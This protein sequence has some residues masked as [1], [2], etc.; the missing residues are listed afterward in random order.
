MDGFV[1]TCFPD[2]LRTTPKGGWSSKGKSLPRG[3][4]SR[5]LEGIERMS[6]LDRGAHPGDRANMEHLEQPLEH[7]VWSV[8]GS[9]RH[10]R[11]ILEKED[12]PL[13]QGLARGSP[14]NPGAQDT[15][16]GGMKP[17]TDHPT[18]LAECCAV[19]RRPRRKDHDS[20]G[21]KNNYKRTIH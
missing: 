1:P 6:K 13:P 2:G 10:T 8:A 16:P 15:V 11:T 5:P 19:A 20:H 7:L 9:I 4:E 21:Y 14:L 18:G 17:L 3:R 12:G